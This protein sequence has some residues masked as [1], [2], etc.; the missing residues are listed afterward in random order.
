MRQNTFSDFKIFVLGTLIISL[1]GAA[2]LPAQ[3]VQLSDKQN[4]QLDALKSKAV[5]YLQD[6]G[7]AEDGSFSGEAGPGITSIVTVALLRNGVTVE[8]PAVAKALNYL[9]GFRRPDGGIYQEGS[10]YRNYETCLAILCFVEANSTGK[11][12]EV[13]DR[14]NAFVRKIQ[15]GSDGS[16]AR[17]QDEFGGS[18]YGKHKRPDLSNTTFLIEAL[19]AA[20]A[21]ADDAA[22]QRALVFVSRSQNL[23]SEHNSTKFAPKI[24]DGGFYYTPAAGGTS[25]AGE[26]ANGGL[27]SYASM[28]YAGLKS[29]IYAGV[30][31]DDQRVKAA[32]SWIRK[33]Y[34]VSQNPGMGAS[35][36]YYYLHT[37]AKTLRALEINEVQSADGQRHN[38]RGDLISELSRRQKR[39][40]SWFNTRNTRWLEGD[41]NL[42]TG[43][44]LLALSYCRD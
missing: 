2:V 19:R 38:W 33:N 7:Q 44:A 5:A 17:N 18:G 26:T 16:V 35:G 39:N 9:S 29:M 31:R 30:D 43:Y 40:G 8:D 4:N 28:T 42:V 13:I 22:I 24:N 3:T 32:L 41:E 23:E 36:H 21:S 34:D 15:V 27:R 20:G 37:F 11:Y 25:Q 1:C 6:I 12:D 14:A 10:L